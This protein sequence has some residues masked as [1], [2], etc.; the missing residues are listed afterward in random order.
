MVEIHS[1]YQG[2][3]RCAS[4]HMP[5]GTVLITDAPADNQG[6]AES[7]S[8]TDLVATALANCILTV[9]GITARKLK[10]DITGTTAVVNK[11]MVVQPKRRISSL[12]VV[13]TFPMAL[14][15]EHRAAL[16]QAALTCPVHASLHPDVAMPIEFRWA[17]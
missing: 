15:D 8:P 9:M 14:A 5:S 4:T 11:A 3:L 6:K 2:E 13:I 1:V 12:S 7:F 17:N 10:I 16:E